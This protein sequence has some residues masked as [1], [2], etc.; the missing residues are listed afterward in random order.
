MGFKKVENT[1]FL[2]RCSDSQRKRYL[3]NIFEAVKKTRS[4]CF[5]G[6]K[7]TAARFLKTEHNCCM[8]QSKPNYNDEG[9]TKSDMFLSNE[10]IRS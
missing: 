1:N 3:W 6:S 4:T 5:I 8:T 2:N 10:L 7:N 9:K